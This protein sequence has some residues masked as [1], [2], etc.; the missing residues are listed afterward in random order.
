MI[1]GYCLLITLSLLLL[2]CLH[3]LLLTSF[4]HYYYLYYYTAQGFACFCVHYVHLYF[5]IK[6]TI[7]IFVLHDNFKYA[8]KWL[9]YHTSAVQRTVKLQQD[10]CGNVNVTWQRPSPF[11]LWQKRRNMPNNTILCSYGSRSFFSSRIPWGAT[12]NSPPSKN[13]ECQ[14]WITIFLKKQWICILVYVLLLKSY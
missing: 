12:K 5:I 7:S 6:C 2:S 9:A 8:N 14:F 4:T 13:H 11:C 3:V 10:L 1:Q